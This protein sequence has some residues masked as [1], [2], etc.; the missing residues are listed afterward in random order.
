MISPLQ[1]ISLK[2][3]LQ[4]PIM[5]DANIFM[6]GI[7]N[8]VSDPNCSFENMKKLYMIPLLESF[9]QIII[10]E[11]VY[12]E[13]DEDSRKLV[14]SYVG[15]NVTI[16]SENNLYGRDPIYTSLFNEISRHERVLYSRGDSKDRG[17]VY[18]L[19]YAAYNKINYFSSKEVMVDIIAADLEVLKDIEIITFDIIVLLSYIYYM[20]REDSSNNKALKSLYKKYCEDVI[21][22]HKLPATLKEYFLASADYLGAY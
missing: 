20:L 4:Q 3:L 14:D 15:K 19:A 9:T 10:H 17:E 16:V 6:V 7:E 22:R 1:R 11:M 21:K 18:S 5:F 12:N 8:R 2:Q 13:L